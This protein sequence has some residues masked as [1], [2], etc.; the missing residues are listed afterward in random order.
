MLIRDEKRKGKVLVTVDGAP[1]DWRSSLA[2]RNHSPTGPAWGCG[3]SGPAPLALAIL[4][5]VP[6][7]ATTGPFYQKCRWSIIAPIEA[8][9]GALDAADIGG[10][11]ESSAETDGVVPL[12]VEER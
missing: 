1:M 11:L 10:W 5:Q 12:A 4:V 3:G 8:D 6:D 7:D 9:R 2:A